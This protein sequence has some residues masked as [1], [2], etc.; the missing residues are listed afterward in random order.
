M[1]QR[2]DVYEIVAKVQGAKTIGELEEGL[3]NLKAELKTKDIGSKEF[4]ELSK[5]IG[6]AE[7]KMKQISTQAAQSGSKISGAFK[8]A[9][10]TI[11]AGFKA[12]T[13]TALM[14]AGSSE[15]SI[16]LMAKLQ[17][18]MQLKEGVA[19][20]GAATKSIH[21]LTAGLGGASKAASVLRLALIATGIGA[22]VV[23]LGSLVAWFTQTTE[24][25]EKMRLAMNVVSGVIS[26]LV[27]RIIKLGGALFK[28]LSGD[29]KGGINDITEAFKGMGDQI[30]ENIKRAKELTNLQNEMK[31]VERD[32]IVALAE[33]N[34]LIAESRELIMDENASIADKEKAVKDMRRAVM[35]NFEMEQKMH[36]MR[37][38]ELKLQQA[39]GQNNINDHIEMQK[40]LAEGIQLEE[41]R[42]QL[43]RSFSRDERRV[44]NE[45]KAAERE[46]IE[47]VKTR[48]EGE[49]NL[50]RRKLEA[51]EKITFEDEKRFLD[52]RNKARLIT[53]E[54]YQIELIELNKKW[55]NISAAEA[56]KQRQQ[57][58]S[59][60]REKERVQQEENQKAK[61]EL[62]RS[63]QQREL[64]LLRVFEEEKNMT[65]EQL[66]ARKQEIEMERRNAEIELLQTQGE[67]TI[68]QEIELAN[69][70]IEIAQTKA[71]KIIA[72]EQRIRDARQMLM[73]ESLN[74]VAVWGD[75]LAKTEA[76]RERARKV[77]ALGEIATDSA[78]A[79]SSLVRN[80]E[81]NPANLLTGGAAGI[82]Q[83]ASGMIRIGANIGKAISILKSGSPTGIS[84]GGGGGGST[85][86][87]VMPRQEFNET[88]FNQQQAS[89]QKV[90]V[91]E[92]DIRG[93]MNT[94][95]NS[96]RVSVID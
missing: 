92:S 9:G 27:D 4:Q 47:A 55:A 14:F 30:E 53:E 18:A 79:I 21:A 63:F 6:A 67:D 57:I 72:E 11:E 61:E 29:F 48:I 40:L 71:D 60:K 24:G 13:G 33:N 58:E 76:G 87:G 75:L 41:R 3:K 16:Q 56:E 68:S 17:G 23:L 81:G 54:E 34:K 44:N 5:E 65:R 86:G 28:F 25:M 7:G 78:M 84:G 22:I 42:S 83:F 10:Q 59:D 70:E 80:S 26:A 15:E 49:I 62:L 1:A 77:T 82:A 32:S 19:S 51:L 2:T 8:A 94:V 64:E 89:P 52:R 88:R 35:E 20:L 45:A 91:V 36:S 74:A 66:E 73:A 39:Q 93:T 96:T 95:A 43:L 90:F 12:A 50:E 85:G 69:K 46:R 38:Q 37:L 31:R